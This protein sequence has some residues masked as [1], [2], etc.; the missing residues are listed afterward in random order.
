MNSVVAS[1][2]RSLDSGP[3]T[4]DHFFAKHPA[5]CKDG[6]WKPRLH[7]QKVTGHTRPGEVET[8]L[9]TLCKFEEIQ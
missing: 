6:L 8:E 9:K 7:P 1:R 4:C 2:V 5:A 3:M